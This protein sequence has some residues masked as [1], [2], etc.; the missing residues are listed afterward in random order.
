MGTI[1]EGA[2]SATYVISWRT[3]IRRDPVY[4]V[5][6]VLSMCVHS[7]AMMMY[8]SDSTS[9]HELHILLSD[10]RTLIRKYSDKIYKE[11]VC[12]IDVCNN[13]GEYGETL[14]F[15]KL[16]LYSNIAHFHV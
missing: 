4:T 16:L 7:A 3:S 10:L 8:L 6:S 9:I 14:F 13:Q 15:E 11:C 5:S 2:S 1:Q 12:I